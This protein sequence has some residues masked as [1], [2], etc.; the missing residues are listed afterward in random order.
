MD[1]RI[2][3]FRVWMTNDKFPNGKM[4]YCG[5]DAPF[6]INL[7]GDLVETFPNKY[8]PMKHDMCWAR[9]GNSNIEIQQ[10]IG[11][12]DK[13]D[14]EIYEGDILTETHYGSE[15][16]FKNTFLKETKLEGAYPYKGVVA[17]RSHYSMRYAHVGFVTYPIGSTLGQV[18]GNEITTPCEVI[19][20]MY[21][22]PELLK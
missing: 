22:N 18:I 13:N 2:L 1:N 21:E 10:Y 5:K 17:Y 16:S 14:K 9:I 20:N 3:K 8:D 15:A 4:Y 6:V 19:G 11:L 12:N 7:N